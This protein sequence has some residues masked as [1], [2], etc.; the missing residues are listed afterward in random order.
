MQGHHR[1]LDAE[2]EHQQGQHP[3][4]G[5]GRQGRGSQGLEAETHGGIGAS[6]ALAEPAEGQHATQQAQARHRPIEQK[7]H[8]GPGTALAAPDRHQQ[9]GGDQHQLKGEH[10]QQGVAG[11]ERPHH[12]QVGGQ[13]QGEIKARAALVCGGGQHRHGGNQAREQ[14]QRQRQPIEAQIKA[15]TQPGQPFEGQGSGRLAPGQQAHHQLGQGGASGETA[16][17]PGAARRQQGEQQAHQQGKQEQQQQGH[18]GG[19]RAERW[20]RAANQRQSARPPSATRRAP[21]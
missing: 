10:E 16:H 21:G 14:H 8:G 19:L 1:Q 2:T 5:R 13:H 20:T 18:G 9:G 4:L 12:P 11:Q 17:Q 6:S 15:Q 3:A 7:A